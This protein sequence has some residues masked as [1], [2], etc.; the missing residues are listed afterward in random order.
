MAWGNFLLDIGMNVTPGAPLTK[1]YAVKYDTANPE[2]VIPVAAITDVIAGFSQFNVST[3]EIT[4]G[5][6]CSCRV[7]GVT[8]AV[9]SGAIPMG[10][11]VTLAADGRVTAAATGAR[12]VGKCVGNP[13]INANDRIALLINPYGSLSP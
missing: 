10:S 9:A 12:V 3:Q 4:K 11:L 7:H 2:A 6:G 5:K 13:A 1:F 8:E